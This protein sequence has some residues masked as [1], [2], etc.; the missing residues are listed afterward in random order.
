MTIVGVTPPEFTGIEIG[1]S[2]DI[3]VPIVMQAEMLGSESRLE[4]PEEWWLQIF[5][6]VPSRDALKGVPYRNDG[7]V[8]RDTVKGVPY[9]NGGIVSPDA[10]KGVPDRNAGI[11]GDTLQ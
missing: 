2:P 4:N 10:L 7:I 3:R 9:R 6:R 8:S 5:G 11:V 1:T